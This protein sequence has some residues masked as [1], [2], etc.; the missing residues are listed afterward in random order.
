MQVGL[1]GRELH[2]GDRLER[3]VLDADLLGRAPRLLRM[4]CGDERNR[5]AVV[6]D[7]IDR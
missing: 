3:L 7:T 6:E 2:V 5:F 4:L 1:L